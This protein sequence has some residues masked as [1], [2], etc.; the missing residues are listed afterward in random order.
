MRRL[1]P[2]L[3]VAAL[4][5]STFGALPSDASAQG[6]SSFTVVPKTG[7]HHDGFRLQWAWKSGVS[8]YELET[9][10]NDAFTSSRRAV[11]VKGKKTRPSKGLMAV[12]VHDLKNA[13]KYKARVRSVSKGKRSAWSTVSV[14]T[15]IHYPG[16]FTQVVAT[17]GPGVGQITISWKQDGSYTTYFR[18]ETGLTTFSKVSADLPR[19]GRNPKLFYPNAKTR[20]YTFTVKQL[21]AAGAHL[22]SGNHLYYRIFAV[23]RGTAGLVTRQHAFLQAMMP[24]PRPATAGTTLRVATFNV[25]TARATTDERSW[26]QRAPDVAREIEGERPGVVALQE[27]SPGRADGRTGSLT[28]SVRQTDSL[29][30]SLRRTSGSTYRLVRATSYVRPGD[31]QGSQGARIL[32]DTSRLILRSVCPESS[33]AGP[34][35]ASCT[36]TLPLLASDSTS[37]QRKAAYAEFEDRN[38]GRRFLFVSAHLDERQSSV[39]ATGRRYDQLRGDQVA[40]VLD[41]VDKINTSHLPVVFA[42]D[43]NSWQA[44]RSGH[45]AHD[46]LVAKGYVDAASANGKVNLQYPTYN[47]FVRTLAV[48]NQGYGNRLDVLMINGGR[49]INSIRNVTAKDDASRPSDHNLVVSDLVL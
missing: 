46:F 44:N 17:P 20:S 29:V 8:Q 36:V 33:P 40:A 37:L 49:G 30:S 22:E 19:S 13:T 31:A 34:Y 2:A 10:T 38:T 25:R 4:F 6:P 35:S 1:F 45:T 15:L 5:F 28:G 21:T 43:I 23:N 11:V 3:L 32:F 47:A 27:L 18:I 48:G 7:Q 39:L 42:G 16:P 24:K 14:S 9:A 41:R 26:L 12:T